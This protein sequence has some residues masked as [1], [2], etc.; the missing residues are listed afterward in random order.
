MVSS[1]RPPDCSD[2]PRNANATRTWA[3]YCPTAADEVHDEADDEE[4]NEE[5]EK[6]HRDIARGTGKTTESEE[7]RDEGDDEEDQS[8]S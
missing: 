5:V 1:K 4:N 6:D 8:V 7:T 2:G 3:L